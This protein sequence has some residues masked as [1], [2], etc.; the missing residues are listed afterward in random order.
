MAKLV[1][2]LPEESLQGAHDRSRDE[3][4]SKALFYLIISLNLAILEL[5]R[6]KYSQKKILITESEKGKIM[7]TLLSVKV[8]SITRNK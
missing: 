7:S 8:K 2:P 5:T 4:T 1:L 6:V 3:V